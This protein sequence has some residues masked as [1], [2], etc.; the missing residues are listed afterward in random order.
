MGPRTVA[1][2]LV[3]QTL[4]VAVL[5]YALID[6]SGKLESLSAGAV[7]PQPAVPTADSGAAQDSGVP[8]GYLT[9]A[10]LRR[11]VA[12]EIKAVIGGNT[13]NAVPAGTET[14]VR[15]AE[16]SDQARRVEEEIEYHI[17]VG[18][19]SAADMEALQ[20]RIATLDP[21]GRKRMLNKL[22]SA[23]NAGL[24]DGRL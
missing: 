20:S 16:K 21:A 17:S 13:G 1:A 23:M 11:I 10:Q 3:V 12:E 15:T 14:D 19:I 22:V 5:A 9:E 8:A 18:S 7:A 4:A 2:I 24:I 6:V